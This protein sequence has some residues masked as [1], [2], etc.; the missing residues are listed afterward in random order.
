MKPGIYIRIIWPSVLLISFFLVFCCGVSAQEVGTFKDKR[1][2]HMYSSIAIGKQVWMAEN[3]KFL[4]ASGAWAYN[5]SSDCI[6]VYGY[7]YE[8]NEAQT[9]CPKGWRLPTADEFGILFES[10]GGE[11]VA[12]SKLMEMD[13]VFW[14]G[15]DTVTGNVDVQQTLLGGTRKG[16]GTY[17]GLRLWGGLWSASLDNEG[18][19]ADFLFGRGDPSVS[20]SA[21]NKS[22][23]FSVRCIRK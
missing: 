23:A 7:L 11:S 22:S 1:D 10:L 18:F 2:G 16:D 13:S 5:D 6:K 20:R 15:F 12:S 4:P 3:L 14:N 8:W 17:S 9:A 19:P 21:H